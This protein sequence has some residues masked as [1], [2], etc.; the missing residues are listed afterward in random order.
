[1]KRLLAAAVLLLVVASAWGETPEVTVRLYWLQA[2]AELRLVPRAP[3][4]RFR[5]CPACEWKPL[6]QPLRVKAAG[7]RVQLEPPLSRASSVEVSGPYTAEVPAQAPLFLTQPLLLRARAGRLL[8]TLRLPLEDYVAAVLA[9]ESS[10]FPSEE[11]LQAM[12]VAVRTY[13]AHFRGRHQ[14]EGFDFCDT[15]HCQ[16]FRLTA[17]SARLRAAAEAT[18]G[19]LLWYEG[20]PAATYYHRHCGGTTEAAEHA[21][22]GQR[23]PYLRQHAD[24]FCLARDRAGWHAE[25]TREELRRALAE[26]GLNPPR[27]LESVTVVARTPSGRAARLRLRGPG[28]TTV[29]ASAFRRAV[30]QALGWDRIRSDFYD[31]RAAGDRFLFDGY[32]S[33]HGVGLCQVGAA[34][35]GEE[36]RSYRQILEFYYPGT[37]LGLTARGFAWQALAGERVELLTTRP[38]D[39]QWLVALAERLLAEAEQR[40]G[41]DLAL[42]PQLRLYPTVAAF[43]NAT[44]QPGWV[45]ASTRGRVIRLQPPQVLRAA[46]TLEATL[47][48][49]FLHQLLESRAHPALPLWFREGLVLYLS[50]SHPATRRRGNFPTVDAL[51]KAL[52]QPRHPA[53]L[54]QAYAAAQAHV[55]DLVA[56][57]GREKMLGWVEQGLPPE[58]LTRGGRAPQPGNKRK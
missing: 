42:R 22:P 20:E 50:E 34:Q 54:R 35:M 12:A 53:E 30:G 57:Y 31:V 58:L 4:A 23:L 47:R 17:A 52:R 37:V 11:S 6:A 21:W 36:G 41:W 56:E 19:E 27:T 43:R 51:E 46:G 40:T 44:G 38:R 55:E 49:E 33:G 25:I 8:L 15:T 32:G 5:L 9:G 45:A 16:D 28:S 1:M 18:E 24:G 2:P 7:E 26:A 13:A 29:S 3:E 39:D 48:H 10:N 14:A